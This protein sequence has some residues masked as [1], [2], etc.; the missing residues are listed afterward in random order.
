MPLAN[1]PMRLFL[2]EI[3]WI[4]TVFKLCCPFTTFHFHFNVSSMKIK[5][6]KKITRERGLEKRNPI[7]PMPI[8]P[9]F[10]LFYANVFFIK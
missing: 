6:K 3:L 5:N 1:A 2:I 9:R 10:G 7:S 4:E 8:S